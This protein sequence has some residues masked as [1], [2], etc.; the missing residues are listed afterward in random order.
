[1][2]GPYA[3]S[4]PPLGL[5]GERIELAHGGGGFKT[6]QLIEDIIRPALAKASDDF[7]HD[8]AKLEIDG[9]RMAFTTDSYVVRPLF[10]PGGDIGTLAI[11]GTVND[12]AMCGAA[13][14]A[15]S[16]ALVLEEGFAI[17]DLQRIATSI[18]AAA[19]VAGVAIVTGDTK[20]VERGKGDGVYINTSGIGR[21]I[22]E[23]PIVPQRVQPG[24]VIILSGDVGRHGVAVMA[25]REGFRFE[26]EIMSDCA[27]LW[28]PVRALIDSGCDLHCLRDLTRGG[29]ATGLIE[30]ALAAGIEIMLDEPAVPV[31][32]PVRGACEILGIDPLYVAN[33]GRFIAVLPEADAAAALQCLRGFDPAAA[34][35]GRVEKAAET[36]AVVVD[37]L[38]GK[39]PLDL[40][41]GEQ[42]PRIC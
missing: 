31:C 21:I 16:L 14:V 33:E 35:I 38:G 13:P 28:A 36:G 17:A 27:P 9:A 20:V 37:T 3:P 6:R 42:L 30:I 41:S 4:C 29:L 12:L 5:T 10:F 25:M 39:R 23:N 18:R 11:H 15:I 19:D 7:T 32:E 22:A 8:G 24:D 1:M 26:T 40:L 34:I 2:I